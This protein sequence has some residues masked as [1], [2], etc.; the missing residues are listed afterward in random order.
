VQGDPTAGHATFNQAAQIA[1]RFGDRDLASIACHGR[2][3]ALI[4]LG[5]IREGVA[6]LDEA[7]VGLIAGEVSP[8]VAGDT[9]CS[10]LE[11]CQEIH[12][13]ALFQQPQRIPQRLDPFAPFVERG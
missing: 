13:D 5:N 11:G 3:R 4:R 12:G 7:M 1:S 10:V 9:Y 6:L 2:G 8:M